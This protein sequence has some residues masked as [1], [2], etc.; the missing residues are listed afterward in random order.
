MPV[1]RFSQIIRLKF[2]LQARCQTAALPTAAPGQSR[3][4]PQF[5]ATSAMPPTA[6]GKADIRPLRVCLIWRTIVSGKRDLHGDRR[7]CHHALFEQSTPGHAADPAASLRIPNGLGADVACSLFANVIG[8]PASASPSTY[9]FVA[10]WRHS[11]RRACWLALWRR[12]STSELQCDSRD[13]GTRL[14]RVAK[15]VYPTR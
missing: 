7:I 14:G 11:L 13:R 3:R 6:T 8:R 12:R 5:A 2:S 15:N 10:D 9:R 4:F 1:P